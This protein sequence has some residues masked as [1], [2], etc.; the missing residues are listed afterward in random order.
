MAVTLLLL[1]LISAALPSG[2]LGDI[3]ILPTYVV[4][5]HYSLNLVL[6]PANTTY[7]GFVQIKFSAATA[8]HDIVKLH[9]SPETI[10]IQNALLNYNHSCS[11]TE[12]NNETEIVTLTCPSRSFQIE[13]TLIVRFRGTI[14][15]EK[16]R[17]LYRR[18][19]EEDGKEEVL[20]ATQFEALD[21]RRAFPCLDEPKWKTTFDV[22]ITHPNEYSAISNAPVVKQFSVA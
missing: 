16:F 15:T 8:L 19:Y 13:N 2:A 6:D 9:A 7:E 4:P 17:G 20:L 10:E 18:S 11:V 14:S 21:A 22:F 12:H 1:F 3:E 5:S